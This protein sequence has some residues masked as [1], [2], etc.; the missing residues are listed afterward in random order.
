MSEHGKKIETVLSLGAIRYKTMK[1]MADFYA[2]ATFSRM[3][4]TTM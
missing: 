2:E 3:I 1:D 4:S